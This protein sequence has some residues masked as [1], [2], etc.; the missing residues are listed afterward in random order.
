MKFKRFRSKP[1]VSPYAPDWDFRIGTSLCE[2]IDT[3]SLFKFLLSKEKEV[4]KLPTSVDINGMLSDGNTG[5][6]FRSTT[7][8]FQ[9]YNI[10]SWNHP[11][12]KKLKSNIAKNIILYNDECGNETPELW[13]HC[14]YNVLRFG[15]SIKPHPHS[16]EPT[17]YLSGH[18]NVQVNDTSTV[19]MTPVNQLNKRAEIDI[20]NIPGELTLFPSYIFHYTTPHYSFRP[21]VT[22]AFDIQF[23]NH[24]DNQ[25]RL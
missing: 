11:E 14:W 12:I 22:I 24:Y 20:K 15:Q 7:A 21:R 13:I 2:D 19:Y 25:I 8:K 9:S 23:V 18:F 17:S 5:L 3:N 16:L 10:F 6:G 1:P 4:K